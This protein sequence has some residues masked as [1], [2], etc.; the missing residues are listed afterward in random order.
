MYNSFFTICSSCMAMGQKLSESVG[1]LRDLTEAVSESV[2]ALR[3]L[4]EAVSKSVGALRDLTEAVSESVGA[5]R[6]LT[7]AVSE[8]VGALR[9]L[10]RSEDVLQGG[11]CA[12]SDFLGSVDDP[13]KGF[14]FRCRAYHVVTQYAS[15][16]SMEQQ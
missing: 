14:A 5:L 13:L 16:L 4:T 9:D 15:T 12:T 7:E 6:D 3:D 2:G 1:A 10:Y 8:S 11:Q